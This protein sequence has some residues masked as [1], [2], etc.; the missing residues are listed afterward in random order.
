MARA[1]SDR[2]ATRPVGWQ[3]PWGWL[4]VVL[5]TFGVSRVWI[6]LVP[7]HLADLLDLEA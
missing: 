2:R 7:S 5:L 4:I 6:V 3:R 1:R